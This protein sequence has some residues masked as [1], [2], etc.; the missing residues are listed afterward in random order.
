MKYEDR[1]LL[2]KKAIKQWGA[3]AQCMMVIEECSELIKALCKMN[4][5][6]D[7]KSYNKQL[8]LLQYEI[9]DVDIMIEQLKVL[10]NSSE[11]EHCKNEKLKRLKERL[12][13]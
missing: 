8:M 10:F 3:E 1:I 11:I 7:G 5:A 9:A 6:K 4:R 13:M 2:Y 12:M